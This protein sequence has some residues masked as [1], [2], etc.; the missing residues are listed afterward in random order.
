VL[1]LGELFSYQAAADGNVDLY[2]LLPTDIS[3]GADTG[4]G[5]YRYYQSVLNL[6]LLAL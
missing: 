1:C 6:A 4:N 3:V 5:A 2:A